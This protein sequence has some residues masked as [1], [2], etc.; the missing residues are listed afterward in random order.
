MDAAGREVMIT[1][2]AVKSRLVDAG[3]A[4]SELTREWRRAA[5]ASFGNDWD[6]VYHE[7]LSCIERLHKLGEFLR[8][9]AAHFHQTETHAA[10]AIRNRSTR[11]MRTQ[12]P[13]Q[14]NL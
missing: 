9:A 3:A 13:P 2:T 6:S 10:A 14:E 8:M 1:A 5:A 12:T 7:G 11:E 4:M